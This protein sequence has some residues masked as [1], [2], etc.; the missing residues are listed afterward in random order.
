[1]AS[2]PFRC[3]VCN[4]EADDTDLRYFRK[5]GM[6]FLRDKETDDYICPYCLKNYYH[7]NERGELEEIITESEE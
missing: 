5:E 1:M 6:N 4:D 3:R 2:M 7:K